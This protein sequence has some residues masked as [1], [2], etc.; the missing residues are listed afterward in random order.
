MIIIK[1]AL[2]GEK[3]SRLSHGKLWNVCKRELHPCQVA[4]SNLLYWV[5]QVELGFPFP[6]R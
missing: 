5:Q 4:T 3:M 1:M 6:I 2:K